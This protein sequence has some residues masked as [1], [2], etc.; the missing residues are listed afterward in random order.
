M[1]VSTLC[2]ESDILRNKV[3][4]DVGVTCLLA[5]CSTVPQEENL[6][7]RSNLKLHVVV[8]AYILLIFKKSDRFT[9][10][11]TSTWCVQSNSPHNRALTDLRIA[12][13]LHV[14]ASAYM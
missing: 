9:S 1:H 14:S 8:S 5:Y 4:T 6:I 2:V 7:Q 13:L 3:H 10:M 12:A 11:H